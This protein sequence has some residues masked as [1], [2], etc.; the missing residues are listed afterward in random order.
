MNLLTARCILPVDSYSPQGLNSLSG[1]S[2]VRR[3]LL[4]FAYGKIIT[5]AA[6]AP[7]TISTVYRSA[8]YPSPSR[9]SPIPPEIKCVNNLNSAN[10]QDGNA[11]D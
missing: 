1:A 4:S 10:K 3:A 6:V 2:V 11:S 7:Y 8:L 5:F 9:Y